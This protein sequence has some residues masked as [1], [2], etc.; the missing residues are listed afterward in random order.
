MN[1]IKKLTLCAFL[2]TMGMALL[3]GCRRGVPKPD[4]LPPLYPCE[5]EV[6]FG[7]EA[8]S[9][10]GVLLRPSDPAMKRW[11][12]G[13]VTDERGVV[14]PNTAHAFPGVAQGEYLVSFS[15]RASVEGGEMGEEV[16]LIPVQYERKH[17]RLTLRVDKNNTHFKWELDGVSKHNESQQGTGT[18]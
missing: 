12:A 10:V 1:R 16:S 2:L 14:R 5:I 13:G 4:G 18:L 8:I 7:G 3:G 11:G 17:S 15:K 9:G 6:T